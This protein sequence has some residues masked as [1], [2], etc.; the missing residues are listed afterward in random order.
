MSLQIL[1]Q[2]VTPGQTATFTFAGPYQITSYVVGISHWQLQYD[3]SNHQTR[4]IEL[5]ISASDDGKQTVYATP[6]A[7][8]N[9]E[10]HDLDASYSTVSLVCIAAFNDDTREY[11]LA[12][13]NG[14]RDRGTSSSITTPNPHDIDFG[15]LNGWN[16]KYS[17]MA[18]HVQ[19]FTA[20]I[21]TNPGTTTTTLTGTSI[22]HD[23]DPMSEHSASN[24]TVD[25]GL[26]ATPTTSP[27]GLLYAVL[28]NRQQN[29]STNLSHSFQA[30]NGLKQVG[31]ML[32][33][34]HA[35][36]PSG[37]HDIKNIGGGTSGWSVTGTTV[38]LNDARAFMSDGK[39]SQDDSQSYVSLVVF[40]VPN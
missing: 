29:T 3:K 30:P 16:M 32:K 15:I 26:V 39:H 7:I 25:G 38:T 23:D 11:V 33:W 18:H 2:T 14:I 37:D 40:A 5:K 34:F 36:Y 28:G 35:M 27:L 17:D 22:M 13:R 31:V 8:L 10:G 20:G 19:E 12:Q 4:Q 6:A 1:S 9:G 21:N 24:P